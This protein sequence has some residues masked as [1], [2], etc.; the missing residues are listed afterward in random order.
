MLE[1]T[2]RDES[3]RISTDKAMRGGKV[4]WAAWTA[5]LFLPKLRQMRDGVDLSYLLGDNEE[6]LTAARNALD[7][8]TRRDL[9]AAI[10]Q[11]WRTIG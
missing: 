3:M 9:E 7:P 2:P 10:E 5:G 4:N 8:A 1:Q 6:N 11:Q